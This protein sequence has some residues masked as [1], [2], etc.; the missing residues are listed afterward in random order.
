MPYAVQYTIS[1]LTGHYALKYSVVIYDAARMEGLFAL[2]GIDA[3][4]GFA[5]DA[6]RRTYEPFEIFQNLMKC[7]KYLAK[8]AKDPFCSGI[9]RSSDQAIM[10]SVKDSDNTGAFE[11]I[12]Y[13]KT[14]LCKRGDQ[15]E[16]FESIV[17]NDDTYR[18]EMTVLLSAF[19]ED[20]SDLVHL[21]E[22]TIA[23]DA[24]IVVQTVSNDTPKP[25]PLI[26]L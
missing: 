18:A 15:V 19:K 7:L 17:G 13:G 26:Q 4:R 8:H 14:G 2:A 12:A 20:L 11:L 5:A 22:E 9:V 6:E 25:A 10:S 24:R 21:C 23:K 3:L 16:P 1:S